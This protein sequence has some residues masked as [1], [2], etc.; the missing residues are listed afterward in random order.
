MVDETILWRVL[1]RFQSSEE[2]LFRSQNL[3]SG[4][5]MLGKVEKG[6]GMGDEPGA[7][8]LANQNSQIWSNGRHAILKLDSRAINRHT[9]LEVF[10]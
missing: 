8:Q 3:D 2:S 7:D 6:T 9:H 5:R 1:A 10:K 4:G